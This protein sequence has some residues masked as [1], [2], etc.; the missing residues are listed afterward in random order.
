MTL[1]AQNTKPAKA[2]PDVPVKSDPVQKRPRLNRNCL[3]T[4][5]VH[6]RIFEAKIPDEHKLED[7]FVPDYWADV[8]HMVARGDIINA[9][10][11]R[12]TFDIDLVVT[13]CSDVEKIVFVAE[14]PSKKLPKPIFEEDKESEFQKID[15]GF[16][17]W[18][19]IRR[20][21]GQVMMKGFRYEYEAENYINI[22]LNQ[23]APKHFKF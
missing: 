3:V 18:S 10:S 1:A 11:N 7:L 23:H 9:F 13:R 17:G 19:V 8:A 15:N 14:R 16:D 21:G 22:T 6:R 2:Q 12:L 20:N 5:G 4:Q